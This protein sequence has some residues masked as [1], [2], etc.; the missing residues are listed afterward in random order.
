MKKIV[1]TCMIGNAL[2]WYDFILY[3]QFAYILKQKFLPD[4]SISEI[5]TFAIFAAGFVVRPLGGIIF[6]NIGDK[7][8][9]RISLVIGILTMVV[10]TTIIGLLPSYNSIGLVAPIILTLVRL[11][12]GFSLGGE[13]SGCVIYLTEHAPANNRGII[14]SIVYIS[15]CLGMLLGIIIAYLLSSLLSK[16]D[17]WSFGWRLPFI[18]SFFVGMIG[19]YIRNS[20]SETPI[21]AKVRD[22]GLVLQYPLRELLLNYKKKLWL[23][24]GLYINVTAPFYAATIFIPNY[25]LTLGYSQAECST[26]GSLTL[27]TMIITFPITAYISDK[28]GRKPVILFSCLALIILTYPIFLMINTKSYYLATTAQILFAV[29]V[30]FHMGAIPTILVELFPTSVRFT[31]VALSCNISAAIFGGTVPMIGAW[32]YQVTG[33]RLAMSYYLTFLAILAIFIIFFYK[34]TYKNII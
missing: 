15:Q 10:P 14:G 20:I 18:S 8:G 28:I 32:I 22:C 30:A 24:I 23:A 34:E 1:L 6:G 26:L 33:D 9:R 4:S 13:F 2:E 16:E 12:Q 11:V 21:Y 19:M 7:F 31:G 29:I 3:A 25:M 17:L 27:V 5:L